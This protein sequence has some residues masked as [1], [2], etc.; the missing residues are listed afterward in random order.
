MESFCTAAER[1]P[2][3]AGEE[4]AFQRPR[5]SPAS[6][7]AVAVSDLSTGGLKLSGQDLPAQGT[8]V[9][10]TLRGATLVGRVAWSVGTDCGIALDCAI[11]PGQISKLSA[12]GEEGL[13]STSP[14][15]SGETRHEALEGPAA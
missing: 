12:L 7:Q 1:A 5:T 13:L 10:L 9:R 3:R 11:G 15:S 4:P 14:E 6:G 2:E 8:R